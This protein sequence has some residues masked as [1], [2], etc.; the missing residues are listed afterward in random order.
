MSDRPLLVVNPT[1]AGGQTGRSFAAMRKTIEARLGDVDVELTRSGGHAADIAERAASESRPYVVA[2]GGDGTFSET[3]NGVLRA[4]TPCPVAMIGAG[5]GGD[6]R[7]TLG[8]EHRLDRYLD[9]IAS[10]ETRKLDVG[11][12]TFVGRDGQTKNHWF[13]NI[14]S[15]GMGGLVDQYVATGSRLLGG[16]AA[17]FMASTKALL[18]VKR[19]NLVCEVT[20]QGG[21]ATKRFTSYMIA[22]CNGRYFGSGMHVAPMAKVDDGIFEVVSLDAPNKVAFATSSQRIYDGKHLDAKGTLHF[23][24]EKIRIDVENEEARPTFLLDVDGEPL[25]G[26]P[27]EIEVVRGG[28]TLRG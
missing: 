12:A 4:K 2:V 13:V 22:I 8:F 11:R 27:L 10:G 28:V 20:Y 23:P 17:Y 6:L 26:L 21:T 7:K 3:V 9:A 5:T 16:T 1:S 25:G 24:C 19:G 18:R 14:L 15:A